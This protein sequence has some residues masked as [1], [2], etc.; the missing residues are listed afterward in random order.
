MSNIH[1]TIYT[2]Q[3]GKEQLTKEEWD[4]YDISK[5]TFHRTDGPAVEWAD[6]TKVWYVEGKRHRTDGPAIECADGDKVWYVDGKKHTEEE[7]NKI[8]IC[9]NG[10]NFVEVACGDYVSRMCTRCYKVEGN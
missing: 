3:N 10:C 2:K 7:F 1:I 9:S 5:V 4:K 6:G 8:V